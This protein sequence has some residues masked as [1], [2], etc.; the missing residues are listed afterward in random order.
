V[1]INQKIILGWILHDYG[2]LQVQMEVE[3]AH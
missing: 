2:C 3:K 1:D